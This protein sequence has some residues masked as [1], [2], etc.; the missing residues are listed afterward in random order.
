MEDGAGL[1]FVMNYITYIYHTFLLLHLY[2]ISI[3]L[4]DYLSE[5]LAS[6]GNCSCHCRR[7]RIINIHGG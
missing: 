4:A 5:C 7:G 1:A 6:D 2:Y 3:A